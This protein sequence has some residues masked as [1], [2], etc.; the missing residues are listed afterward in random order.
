VALPGDRERLDAADMGVPTGSVVAGFNGSS[1]SLLAL[2]WA[3]VESV[4]LARPLTVVI[5]QD[6]ISQVVAID[7]G[8]R[9]RLDR[10]MATAYERLMPGPAEDIFVN[11]VG[12]PPYRALLEASVDAR[13]LVL[14]AH[15]RPVFAGLAPFSVGRRV[16]GHTS[17][18]VVVVR[19]PRDP[20]SRTVLVGLEG[21]G[22]RA[23]LSFGMDL[24]SRNEMSVLALSRTDRALAELLAGCGARYPEV[25]V[26]RQDVVGKPLQVLA[27]ASRH[28]SLAVA[29]STAH[30]IVRRAH[31]PVA[32]AR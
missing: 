15:R 32:I 25:T 21:A 29:G 22:G 26:A 9:E 23:A 4:R 2:D 19:P 18:P 8:A 6:D 11:L 31:C 27:E 17:C 1:E 14:G 13:M 20:A 30:G 12:G 7:T 10:L 3:A 5:A 16:I 28:A 24:A